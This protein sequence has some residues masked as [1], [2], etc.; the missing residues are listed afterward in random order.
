MAALVACAGGEEAAARD[1]F[2][3][4]LQRL[5]STRSRSVPA[6]PAPP[7][8]ERLAANL[9][10]AADAR[11][12][13]AGSAVNPRARAATLL[14][15]SW[16]GDASEFGE[17]PASAPWPARVEAAL[18]FFV[19]LDASLVG[20]PAAL[21]DVAVLLAEDDPAKPGADFGKDGG[22]RCDPYRSFAAWNPTTGF[23]GPHEFFKI[24]YRRQIEL[25]AHD[26]WT[27][28]PRSPSSRRLEGEPPK[29]RSGTLTLKVS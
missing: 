26:S 6:A 21:F 17:Y 9:S 19:A 15:V 7:Q 12:R 23:G 20:A 3:S 11:G 4:R 13:Y 18:A 8:F 28:R 2:R 14:L 5:A 10:D 16:A 22:G 27:V 24:L 25:F 1:G 29:I